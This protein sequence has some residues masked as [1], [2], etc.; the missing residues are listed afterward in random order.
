M[1]CRSCGAS[2]SEDAKFCPRCGMATSG[3]PK[4]TTPLGISTSSVAGGTTTAAALASKPHSK[5]VLLVEER[6]VIRRAISL[7]R[8]LAPYVMFV[9][10]AVTSE[11]DRYASDWLFVLGVL[12]FVC[13]PTS[14]RWIIGLLVIVILVAT[15]FVYAPPSPLQGP[16]LLNNAYLILVALA[17]ML[18]PTEWPFWKG[19]VR[20]FLDFGFPGLPY[21]GGCLSV[22]ALLASIILGAFVILL[23][24]KSMFVD[25]WSGLLLLVVTFYVFWVVFVRKCPRCRHKGTIESYD[26]ME[27]VTQAPRREQKMVRY[28]CKRCGWE[29]LVSG[30]VFR[31]ISRGYSIRLCKRV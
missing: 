5:G 13:R 25:R 12:Y 11:T 9:A 8:V 1:V 3:D 27:L 10:S 2:H 16:A 4:L 15:W 6:S 30:G 20:R 28:T 31:T 29:E 19:V 18:W 21:S 26:W 17:F 14:L 24:F 7:I 23:A 22:L